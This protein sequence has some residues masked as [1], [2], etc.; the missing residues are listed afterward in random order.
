[1]FYSQFGEDRL[2]SEIFED[3]VKGCCVEV[4]A[5]D[6]IN[7]S[8]TYYFEQLGWNCLLV[9]PNPELCHE[10]RKVRRGPLFECAASD[11]RG[12]ASLYVAYGAQ[13][14][15][16]VSGL[17]D[18]QE[19][20]QRIARFG[21]EARPVSVNTRRL[22]DILEEANLPGHLDF[23]TIDVEGHEIP[24]L[25]GF[26]L[27]RWQPT[28]LIVEDNSQFA[29]SSVVRY[30]RR[31]DYLP[32]RRT[33][34]NDWYAHRT[35]KDLCTLSGQGAWMTA[36]LDARIRRLLRKLPGAQHVKSLLSRT[37]R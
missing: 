24:V 36:A 16:G 29:D 37:S 4:G 15:H 33:G 26:T 23:V 19:V 34:V 30:L 9:E 7:D 31:H 13:R 20:G 3:V 18:A 2:L 10:I 35:R 6:G 8:T 28:I 12:T 32:F 5:N 22:D 27:E 17:G 21:F 14:A 25:Q 11:A 1:M